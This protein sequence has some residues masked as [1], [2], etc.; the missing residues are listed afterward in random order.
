MDRI[1]ALVEANRAK[2]LIG[3]IVFAVTVI[4]MSL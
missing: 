3:V 1:K 2:I 4:G